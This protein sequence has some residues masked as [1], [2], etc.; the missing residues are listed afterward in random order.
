MKKLYLISIFIVAFSFPD[1]LFSLDVKNLIVLVKYKA[2]PSQEEKA[3][4]ALN[5][6]IEQVKREPN[7]VKIVIHVDPADR[8]NILLYEEW[9][10]EEYYKGSHMNTPHL[11]KFIIDSKDFLAGPPEISFWKQSGS[12][13]QDVLFQLYRD[14]A[15]LARDATPIVA[16]FNNRVKRIRPEL[17]FNVGFL[18]YT[19]P[20]MVYYAPKSKNVVTSLYHELP[21]EHKT[22]FNTYSD[23][24]EDAKQFFAIF[25]NG[26]YIAHELGHGLV[27][28][29]EFSDPKAMYWE[30][31]E[32]NLIAMNYWSSVGKTAELEKCYQFAKAF[33]AKVPDPVPNDAEDRIAWFNENYWELGPQPEK[34]GYFQLSQFV[35]IYENHNRIHIDEYLE[36]YISQLEERA[37]KK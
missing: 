36:I 29:F 11:K 30:E 13:A 32:A 2:Q 23:N 27:S 16:D 20:G 34:Y 17:A 21:E 33:L 19:T 22:F 5:Q 14:S 7:Y 35:D 9:S 28:A 4:E 18:V 37:K 6:L 15:S 31:F 24:E 12:Q 25:F 10:D 26:F 8:S 3:L 1:T